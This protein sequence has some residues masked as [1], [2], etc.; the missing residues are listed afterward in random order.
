MHILGWAVS[1][2]MGRASFLCSVLHFLT[3]PMKS[4]SPG[5]PAAMFRCSSSARSNLRCSFDAMDER[6]QNNGMLNRYENR[7]YIEKENGGVLIDKASIVSLA[8]HA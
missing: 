8:L 1:D 3:R 6:F 5:F 4:T 2:S 7:S